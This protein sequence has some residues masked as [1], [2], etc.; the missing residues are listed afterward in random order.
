VFAVA[1]LF[2]GLQQRVP[3]VVLVR[4]VFNALLDA[5]IGAV[6][7]VGSVGDIF[8]RANTINLQLL[9]RHARPGRPPTRGDY[10]FVFG[11]AAVFGAL[12]LVPFLIAIW[13]ANALWSLQG[14][15]P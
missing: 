7:V 8:W 13:L 10:A 12:T 11:L 4:M 3:R 9:E 14:P 2:R 15:K 6:P 1:L 5:L